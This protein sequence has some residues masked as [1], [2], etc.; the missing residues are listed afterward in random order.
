MELIVNEKN[1]WELNE[2]SE[3]KEFNVTLSTAGS[4]VDRNI[5]LHIE[6]SE[7]KAV[8][9][10]VTLTVN[11]EINYNSEKDNYTITISKTT[12][13]SPEVTPGWIEQGTPG[14]VTITGGIEVNKTN[15]TSALISDSTTNSGYSYYR[16]S[17]SAGYNDKDLNSDIEVYQGDFE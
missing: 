15:M 7:G 11:P 4:F 3:S 10:P 17:A 14:N 5:E 8:I 16:T 12:Q 9:E 1:N 2:V 13:L 6:A